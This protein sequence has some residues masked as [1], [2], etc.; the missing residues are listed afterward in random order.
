MLERGF[1]GGRQL[2]IFEINRRI[3]DVTEA[4]RVQ[5]FLQEADPSLLA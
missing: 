2:V 5:E 4:D 1:D 3:G